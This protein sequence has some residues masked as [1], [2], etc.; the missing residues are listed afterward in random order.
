[1]KGK[2]KKKKEEKKQI[3]LFLLRPTNE[4]KNLQTDVTVAIY[5]YIPD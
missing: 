1:M 4:L 2:K 3:F 5:Q